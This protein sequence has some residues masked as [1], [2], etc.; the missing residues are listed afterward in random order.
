VTSFVETKMQHF[1]V[2]YVCPLVTYLL[3]NLHTVIVFMVLLISNS[4]LVS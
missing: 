1:T 3:Y 2:T 4:W